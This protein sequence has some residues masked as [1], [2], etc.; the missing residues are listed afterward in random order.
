MLG[1]ADRA[2][3]INN[4]DIGKG[5]L[6]YITK[7]VAIEAT[8]I[9]AR[10][11]REEVVARFG[12]NFYSRCLHFLED[13]GI[14]VLADARRILD[15][16]PRI[17]V[18]GMHDPTEGGVLMG[19]YEMAAGAGLGLTLDADRVP[20]FGETRSLS[21]HFELSPLGLIASGALLVSINRDDASLLE[22]LFEGNGISYI[23]VFEEASGQMR[24]CE[25]GA[26][27]PFEPSA[28]D[29]LTKLFP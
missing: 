28:Q 16:T 21:E 8:S 20:V 2:R 4:R 29:E 14:S 1:E 22:N 25:K 10:E 3:L 9:I 6:L 12:E 27:R 11:K 13:P 5:D 15:A 18:T 7:G 23:G 24:L 19:A 17:R 26:C